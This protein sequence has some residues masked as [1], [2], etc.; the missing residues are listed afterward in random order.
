VISLGS[1]HVRLFIERDRPFDEV[2]ESIRTVLQICRMNSLPAAIVISE[3]A[4]F[5]WRSSMRVAIR[6]VAIRWAVSDTKLALV[7][8]NVE[9]GICNEVRNV[10]VEAGFDCEIFDEEADAIAWVARRTS[11]AA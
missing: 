7:V 2:T 9:E 5:D 10:A 6:F 11:N 3:Q 4:G 1:H 8:F